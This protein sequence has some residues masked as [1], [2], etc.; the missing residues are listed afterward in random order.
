[1][2]KHFL[3]TIKTLIICICLT[4]TLTSCNLLSRFIDQPQKNENEYTHIHNF[5]EKNTDIEYLASEASCTYVAKY[6]YSCYCG[7][8]G[9][10]TFDYGSKLEH[11]YAKALITPTCSTLGYT[12]Y[13][14]ACGEQYSDNYVNAL[15]HNYIQKN[16]NERYLAS[17]ADCSNTAKYYYSCSC[18][19]KGTE[20]FDTYDYNYNEHSFTIK[21]TSEKYLKSLATI[22]SPAIYYYS[23]KCGATSTDTFTHGDSIYS[24]GLSYRLS[25]DRTYYILA[26]IGTCTDN[27]VIIPSTYNELPVKCIGY[28]AFGEIIGTF[29]YIESEACKTINSIYIPDSITSIEDNAF[30]NCKNL[31]NVI[32]GNGVTHIA[33]QAFYGCSSLQTVRIGE[34]VVSIG[35]HAFYS[36]ESLTEIII[37]DSV[38]TIENG[39]FS[40]CDNL[41]KIVIG[42]GL[43]DF[44]IYYALSYCNKLVEIDVSKENLLYTSIDG[45]LYDKDCKTL[46]KYSSGKRN[47]SFVIPEGVETIRSDAFQDCSN[48]LSVTIPST[49]NHLPSNVLGKFD[50]LVEIINLSSVNLKTN[51]E[52]NFTEVH[53]GTTKLVN[54]DNFIFYEHL[55]HNYLL[56]YVG[57]ATDITLPQTYNNASYSIFKYAFNACNTLTDITIPYGVIEIGENAFFDCQNLVNVHISESVVNIYDCVFRKCYNLTNIIVSEKNSSYK[58]VS[59]ILYS[60]NGEILIQYPIGKTNT[61]FIIPDGVISISNYAFENCKNLYDLTISNTV[62]SIGNYAFSKCNYLKNI[63]F[64]NSVLYIKESAFSYCDNLE[65]LYIPDNIVQIGDY[66]FAYCRSLTT[67]YI[68]NN[69]K[70]I[71]QM[72]FYFCDKLKE[73]VIG[74][75]INYLGDLSFAYTY[76]LSKMVILGFPSIE[77]YTFLG[78]NLWCVFCPSNATNWFD[79]VDSGLGP[80]SIVTISYSETEPTKEG[81]FWHY[82]ENGDIVIW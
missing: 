49:V 62:I 59:G 20:T 74:T 56:A 69:T 35:A 39:A 50:K 72:A 77:Y 17:L 15:E 76:S 46:I 55:G 41:E 73:V 8:K 31:T 37:P 58:D 48:L 19:K 13:T 70:S 24:H 82:D 1:M 34:N 10:D 18:G 80:G 12:S 40:Y 27:N 79:N 23:C 32:I 66:A 9:I 64:G 14:C 47:I 42:K 6:F 43:T 16:T 65:S 60:K 28:N 30:N 2:K 53:S 29:G 54:Y 22:Y 33:Q 71:G 11:K 26:G 38:K 68:G 78:T 4:I 52:D 7:E 5:V 45:N 36:C 3:F 67:A 61:S 51:P 44:N 25:D 63:S 75:G 81:K 21:D 57:D